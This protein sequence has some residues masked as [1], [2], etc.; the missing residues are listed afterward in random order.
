MTNLNQSY[1]NQTLQE[2]VE[3]LVVEEISDEEL[4]QFK[5]EDLEALELM[6]KQVED[7]LDVFKDFIEE[8]SNNKS[9]DFSTHQKMLDTLEQLRSTEVGRSLIEDVDFMKNFSDTVTKSNVIN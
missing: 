1:N 6:L 4:E 7:N 3:E 2:N 9:V 5:D 8:F